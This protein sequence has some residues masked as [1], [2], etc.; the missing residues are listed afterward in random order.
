MRRSDTPL[1]P[2]QGLMLTEETP[3]RVIARLAAQGLHRVLDRRNL[4][5]VALNNEHQL[6]A[7]QG[8]D[9]VTG[10]V[11]EIEQVSGLP[12]P[13]HVTIYGRMMANTH[14]RESPRLFEWWQLSCTSELRAFAVPPQNDCFGLRKHT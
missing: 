6:A 10:I 5:V 3:S 9:D 11:T 4:S 7:R 13:R 2:L 12:V 8:H 1:T 14:V